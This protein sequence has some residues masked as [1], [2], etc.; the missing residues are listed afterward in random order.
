[1]PLSVLSGWIMV[2]NRFVTFDADEAIGAADADAYLSEDILSME[3]VS[4]SQ[5]RL[6][7]VRGQL[8]HRLGWYRA[9][10]LNGDYRLSVL[11]GGWDAPMAELESRSCWT[12]QKRHQH[13]APHDRQR[14]RDPRHRPPV[15]TGPSP[16]PRRRAGVRLQDPRRAKP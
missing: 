2:F 1:M 12:I 15:R 4:S 10:D 13:R 11:R 7:T 3:N 9:G 5:K 6:E 14:N 8:D 16:R